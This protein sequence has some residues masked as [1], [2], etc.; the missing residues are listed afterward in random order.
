MKHVE[1]Q[2]LF[3]PDGV[4]HPAVHECKYLQQPVRITPLNMDPIK[5]NSHAPI[6]MTYTVKKQNVL[7]NIRSLCWEWSLTTDRPTPL[8]RGIFEVNE[9][10]WSAVVTLDAGV[11]QKIQ[12]ICSASC[13]FWINIVGTLNRDSRWGPSG[14]VVVTEQ[15]QLNVESEGMKKD[16][17]YM[18]L[19][20]MRINVDSSEVSV[21]T[22]TQQLVF[23][24]DRGLL[25]EFHLP[26]GLN[27]LAGALTPNVTRAETD[28]DRGGVEIV[29]TF[30]DWPILI[31]FAFLNGI[32]KKGLGMDQG[33]VDL[34]RSFSFHWNAVGLS[35]SDPPRVECKRFHLCHSEETET[36]FVVDTESLLLSARGKLIAIDAKYRVHPNAKI[37]LRFVVKPQNI[38]YNIPSLPRIGSTFALHPSLYNITYWGRGA[39]E[40]YPDRKSAAH[41]GLWRSTPLGIHV[42][43][44]IVPGENGNRTDCQWVSFLDDNGS[45][46]LILSNGGVFCF[47]A[48]LWSQVDLHNAKHTSELPSRLNG[49]NAVYV[50]VDHAL[51][52]VGGDVGCV[53]LLKT[54]SC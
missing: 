35:A 36:S 14:H 7:F 44:Y 39:F 24:K 52:G 25:T 18:N 40:N 16:S 49:Q 41:F 13:G 20:S 26:S 21:M 53:R 51:M 45:G 15:C 2:G 4:P 12:N 46:I 11:V 1:L 6:E 28:N 43:E 17:S 50:N 27:I 42:H 34:K 33:V 37:D 38:L 23:D 54:D 32:L 8:A 10:D 47:S 48:S 9:Q 22:A 5:A 31:D 19:G 3:S 30:F 29:R